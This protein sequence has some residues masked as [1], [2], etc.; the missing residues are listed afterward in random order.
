MLAMIS[1]TSL[2]ELRIPDAEFLAELHLQAFGPA[3]AWNADTIR[4]SLA[5]PNVSGLLCIA[6]QQPA[7]FILVSRAVDEAEILTLCVAP[8]FQRKNLASYLVRAMAN[9][10]HKMKIAKIFLEVAVTNQ[11]AC[12]LY[13]TLGFQENSIR[14]NYYRDGEGFTDASVMASALPLT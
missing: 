13:R 8:A 14:K 7:G 4:Q 10:L 1:T 9:D 12:A 2:R 11:A 6:G 5:Q 3:K